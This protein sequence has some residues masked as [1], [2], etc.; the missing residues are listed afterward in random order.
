MDWYLGSRRRQLGALALGAA[1][2]S[3]ALV[4]LI[5]ELQLL[6]ILGIA[7]WFGLLLIACRP[8]LGLYAAL[9]LALLF[10]TSGVDELMAPGRYMFATAFGTGLGVSGTLVT[11]LEILLLLVL[12]SLLVRGI[13]QRQLA[14]RAGGLGWPMVWF[15][16]ALVAGLVWGI[17]NG[18][19]SYVAFWEARALLYVPIC[20]LVAANT[21]RTREHLRSLITLIF[22]AS[23]L[24]AIEGAY[25]YL[26]LIQPGVLTVAQEFAYDHGSVVVLASLLLLVIAQ[27]IFGGPR[28]Q[29]LA[30]PGVLAVGAL[31]LLATQRRAGYIA[32]MIAFLALGLVL[33]LS[34]RKAFLLLVLPL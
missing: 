26:V 23:T 24:Y 28:W 8:R 3:A 15:V 6:P 7:T 22:G 34:H 13:A 5:V 31:T 9:G 11:P 27:M 14:V 20:F 30:A 2:A 32:L 25:R 12:F 33:L 17:L 10:E 29:R 18:G 16:L 21:I 1:L 19:D 4:P